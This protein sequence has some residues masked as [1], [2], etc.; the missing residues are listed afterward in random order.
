MMPDIMSGQVP[1]A[2][3]SALAAPGPAKGG[4][5]RVLAVTSPQRMPTN[6]D[7]PAMAETLA[8]FSPA[9]SLFLVAPPGTPGAVIQKLSS[10]LRAALN[11]PEVLEHLSKQ[12]ATPPPR[13]SAE[14]RG[15][16][17]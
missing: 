10:A 13:T 17:G 12:G 9:P 1:I 2:V 3:I 14:L 6:P 15:Q 11:A 4:R 8:G 16:T 7:W 5:V